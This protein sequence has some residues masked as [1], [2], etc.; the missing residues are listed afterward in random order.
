MEFYLKPYV[1][2]KLS[3][4]NLKSV[5][6]PRNILCIKRKK[7]SGELDSLY[8]TALFLLNYFSPWK[9]KRMICGK[10]LRIYRN[11]FEISEHK[12]T[13]LK[14]KIHVSARDQNAHSWLENMKC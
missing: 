12:Y 4:C 14:L 7:V 6:E 10:D 9:G 1:Y 2:Q 13:K 5:E 3:I 11:I 8:L